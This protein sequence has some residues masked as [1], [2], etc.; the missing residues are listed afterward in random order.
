VS[1]SKPQRKQW[2][3][4]GMVPAISAVRQGM[5]YKTG[6]K[7]HNVPRS[8]LQKYSYVNDTFLKAKEAV[9]TALGRKP[10]LCR[11]IEVILFIYCLDINATCFGLSAADVYQLAI[12]SGLPHPFT[13]DKTARK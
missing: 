13:D 3:E 7:F 5:S 8:T 2:N 9:A 6:D 11:E 4:G 1:L 10:V 12:R